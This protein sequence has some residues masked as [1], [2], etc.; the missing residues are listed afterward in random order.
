MLCACA[1]HYGGLDVGASWGI[2]NAVTGITRAIFGFFTGIFI[3]QNRATLNRNLIARRWA[4][5]LLIA[6]CLALPS[7]GKLNAAFDLIAVICIFPA[8]VLGASQ[9]KSRR[10][11]YIFLILGSASYPVYVIHVPLSQLIRH[12]FAPDEIWSFIGIPFI[13]G[14]I[15]LGVLIEKYYDIPVRRWLSIRKK[16]AAGPGALIASPD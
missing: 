11:E 8:C 5:L 12:Q 1:F 4:T 9:S 16:A 13:F 3:Y 14:L 15:L 7:L 2:P 6:I 10:L